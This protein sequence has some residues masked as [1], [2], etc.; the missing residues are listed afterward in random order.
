[1]HVRFVTIHLAG[2]R[3]AVL[4]SAAALAAS[5]CTVPSDP[6]QMRA[7]ESS[8]LQSSTC[9]HDNL[10]EWTDSS[11]L[12]TLSFYTGAT[13]SGVANGVSCAVSEDEMVVGGGTY[14]SGSMSAYGFM[15]ASLP[16]ETLRSWWGETA[17]ITGQTYNHTTWAIGLKLAGVSGHDLR[18][19]AIIKTAYASPGHWSA[20]SV[21]VDPGYIMVGGGA[22][23]SSPDRYL[24]ASY[25]DGTNEW[26]AISKDHG[27][28][29]EGR[30]QIVLIEL[31]I[32]PPGFS[33]TL[34]SLRR[35]AAG[36]W[37]S[38]GYGD[39]NLN[40]PA[41]EWALTAIGGRAEY[42]GAGRM[43]RALNFFG[44]GDEPP[45]IRTYAESLDVFSASS[46]TTYASSL[47][48]RAN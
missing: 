24:V 4:T 18:D 44:V 16:N 13:S 47:F 15:V 19:M 9:S 28:S 48:I 46:G 21:E 14:V 6:L 42:S 32:N 29:R 1:M 31:P 2:V 5:G 27:V 25:P 41:D 11:G 17:S 10:V 26:A 20:G 23:A 22:S 35:G 30:V 7:S 8:S 45:P 3:R 36:T 39:A 38:T 37:V 34:E 33:G 12:V 40:Y 43:L